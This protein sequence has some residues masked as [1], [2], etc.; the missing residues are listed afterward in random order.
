M[1]EDKA[2][3]LNDIIK[4]LCEAANILLNEKDYDGHG[5]EEIKHCLTLAEQHLSDQASEV[6]VGGEVMTKIADLVKDIR[7]ILKSTSDEN[8]LEIF[9]NITVW[10][11][12]GGDN[13]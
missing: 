12:T 1:Y 2:W 9:G 3:T 4:K 5:H 10:R 7:E 6:G 11:L 8:R 13:L